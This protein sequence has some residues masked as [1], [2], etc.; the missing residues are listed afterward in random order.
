MKIFKKS[1][2][3]AFSLGLLL[4]ANGCNNSSSKTPGEGAGGDQS[5]TAPSKVSS[6]TVMKSVLVSCQDCHTGSRLPTL[7]SPGLVKASFN[8]VLSEVE[9]GDM[10]PQDRGYHPL[11]ACQIAILK[12]WGELG[13]PD[14]SD[15]LVASLPECT[16]I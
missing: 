10:P 4:G 2:L 12:K 9:G 7:T 13:S 15:V 3:A 11:T 1:A 6:E 8:M 16:H 5:F 14:T